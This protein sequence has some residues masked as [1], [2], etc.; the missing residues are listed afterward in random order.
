MDISTT[1]GRVQIMHN[2]KLFTD[3]DLYNIQLFI[4]KLDMRF[5]DPI[6]GPGDDGMRKL[7][8]G[9]RGLSPLSSLLKRKAYFEVID[10]VRLGLRYSYQVRP[11]HRGM[12]IFGVPPEEIGVGHLEGWGAGR[13]HLMRPDELIMRESVRRQLGLKNH[14]MEMMLWGYVDPI[15]GLD[16]PVGAEEKYMSDDEEKPRDGSFSDYWDVEEIQE[17]AVKGSGDADDDEA[18]DDE[19]DDNDDVDYFFGSGN[20]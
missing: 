14:I 9:Q 15:T 10:V 18:E 6:D 11:E 3:I 7:F 12:E 4:V 13:V 1:A 17:E 16:I 5:N 2:Q 20:N 19:E 8:L